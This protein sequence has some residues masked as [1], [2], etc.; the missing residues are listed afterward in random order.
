MEHKIM[1]LRLLDICFF[2]MSIVR[3][4]LFVHTTT[5]WRRTRSPERFMNPAKTTLSGGIIPYLPKGKISRA[6][7]RHSFAGIN[8]CEGKL[9]ERHPILHLS[10][11]CTS[12][13]AASCMTFESSRTGQ[14]VFLIA[15]CDMSTFAD[16]CI[17]EASM[18]LWQDPGMRRLA[19]TGRSHKQGVVGAVCV[20][21]IRVAFVSPAEAPFWSQ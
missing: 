5:R 9:Q 6:I 8:I 2:I 15:A 20:A 7:D 13:T 16:Q 10:M 12:I 18:S 19:L 21:G 11:T 1:R 17:S 14:H 3:T 4:L